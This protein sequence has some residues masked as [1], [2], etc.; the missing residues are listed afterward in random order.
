MLNTFGPDPRNNAA[1]ADVVKKFRDAGFEPE[2][3]T[4]Y[5]YAAIQVLAQAIDEDRLGRRRAEG[6]GDDQV[7]RPVADRARRSR[8]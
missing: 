4:L 6:R 3:Y 2:A 7:G 8:L 1:A 5:S